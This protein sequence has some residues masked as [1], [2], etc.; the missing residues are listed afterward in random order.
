M[1][2]RVRVYVL[3]YVRVR[4]CV[5]HMYISHVLSPSQ[6]VAADRLRAL[7]SR[8]AV[9]LDRRHEQCLNPRERICGGQAVDGLRLGQVV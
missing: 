7:R 1:R 4:T 5:T 6:H 2:V 9:R 8:L 3:Q